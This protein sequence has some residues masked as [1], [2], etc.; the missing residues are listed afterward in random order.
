[1]EEEE[2]DREVD[3]RVL[4]LEPKGMASERKRENEER[5]SERAT[6][7]KRRERVSAA[8]VRAY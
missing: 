4:R 6:R 3:A 8:F 1:M 7:E 2:E 5:D